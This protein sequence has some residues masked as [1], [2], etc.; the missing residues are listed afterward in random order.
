M[1]MAATEISLPKSEISSFPN[2]KHPHLPVQ[3]GKIKLKHLAQNH[4]I[5]RR[6]RTEA[7]LTGTCSDNT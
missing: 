4:K 7:I 2:P 6:A 1:D 5:D 3:L